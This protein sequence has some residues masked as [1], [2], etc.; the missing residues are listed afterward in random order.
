MSTGAKIGIGCGVTALI[1][2]ILL[3]L[4]VGKC[5]HWVSQKTEEAKKNPDK[6]A[7]EMIVKFN[8]EVEKVSE[9]EAEGEMT[10]RNKKTGEVITLKYKDLA[11]GR[12]TVKNEKGEEATFGAAD[13]SKVPVWVPRVQDLKD[14]VS[15]FQSE[16][17]NEVAGSYAG[18]STQSVEALAEYFAAEASKMEMTTKTETGTSGSGE[19]SRF[20]TYKNDKRSLQIA[21]SRKQGGSDTEVMVTYQESKH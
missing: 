13:L 19:N 1:A 17:G 5:A 21:L 10:I 15:A 16:N 20:L 4:A 14:A 3:A 18:K 6:V 9:N 8:P 11:E 2:C 12:L 7:A